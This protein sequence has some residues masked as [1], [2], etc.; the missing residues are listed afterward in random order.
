MSLEPKIIKNFFNEE[1]RDLI[2]NEL[3]PLDKKNHIYDKSFGRYYSS[4]EILKQNIDYILNYARNIFNSN[5]LVPS[6]FLFAHYEGEEASLFKH[7][8]DN[9]CTYTIDYCLYQS[10]PWDIFIEG[11]P[12]TLN[13]NDAVCFYGEEQ[14]HWREK[15]PN[16][17]SQYVGMVFFHF[18]EPEHWY[19]TK[20]PEYIK[21]IRSQNE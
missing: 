7:V 21:Q 13:E 5:T 3:F 4:P 16:P 2:K 14:T 19:I 9:A 20:G 17:T 8:D 1:Q 18:V 10:E 15:F 12:Y 11:K 6:Y